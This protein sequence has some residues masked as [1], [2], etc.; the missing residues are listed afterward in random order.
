MSIH[1]KCFWVIPFGIVLVSLSGCGSRLKIAS[2]AEVWETHFAAG[3]LAA[4]PDF[5]G[6][7]SLCGAQPPKL[8]AERVIAN[9][10]TRPPP[11][12]VPPTRVFDNLLFVG[13]RGISAWV[14]ETSSGL[15]LIDT[16]ASAQQ[17]EDYIVEGLKVLGRNPADIKVIVITHGHGDHYGGATHLVQQFGPKVLMGAPDWEILKV[18]ENRID[19][20]GWS[21]VPVPDRTVSQAEVVTLGNTSVR[22]LLTPGHTP[23]TLSVSFDVEDGGRRHSV[24]LWGGTG[25]NFGQDVERLGIY[26]DSAET[27]RGRVL[28]ENIDVLLSNHANRDRAH[29]KIALL[30]QRAVG[31]SHSFVM[32]SERVARAFE[33]FRECALGHRAA[34]TG[35]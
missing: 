13:H 2:E 27:M 1:S 31:D 20:P 24:I 5:P 35:N 3:R 10:G 21:Q 14:I 8:T 33:V 4:H 11:K 9:A 6:L 19:S 26:A 17:A 23:G 30:K 16:L 34:L 22:L 18:P 29:E 28:A 25:F 32:S 15:I 12:S 7:S